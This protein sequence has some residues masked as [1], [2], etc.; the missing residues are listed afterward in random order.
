MRSIFYQVSGP[1]GTD[2]GPAGSIRVLHNEPGPCGMDQ[3]PHMNQGPQDRSG[4]RGADQGPPGRIRA[5]QDVPR[6][7]SAERIRTP[8]YES[9]PRGTDQDSERRIS[10]RGTNQG[11]AGRSRAPQDG[12]GPRRT[13]Q[14]PSKRIRA[15]QDELGPQATN[16]G[17]PGRSGGPHTAYIFLQVNVPPPPENSKQ[18]HPVWAK[19]VFTPR[20]SK[21]LTCKAL[22]YAAIM[23]GS[24]TG[25]FLESALTKSADSIVDTCT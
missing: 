3:G 25:K 1:R 19:T 13:Y 18:I 11:P 17:S 20:T 10:A 8:Q 23:N 9:G 16:Q 4:S 5:P 22:K 2:R 6:P 21:L 12:L 14:G 7:G 15:P 24:T